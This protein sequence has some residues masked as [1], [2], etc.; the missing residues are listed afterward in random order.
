MKML[1]GKNLV[2]LIDYR[3]LETVIGMVADKRMQ[4]ADLEFGPLDDKIYAAG[5]VIRI[6]LQE[7][8]D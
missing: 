2:D 3:Q 6:D 8:S 1:P 7:K 5:T 4:R